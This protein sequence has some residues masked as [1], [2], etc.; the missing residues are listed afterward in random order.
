MFR[1]A[2]LL[3][4]AVPL[5]AIADDSKWTPY[6]SKEGKFTILLPGTPKE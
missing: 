1:P 3:I 2:V 4:F 6:T 5:A